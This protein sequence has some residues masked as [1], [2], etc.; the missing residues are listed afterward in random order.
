MTERT[1]Y[2]KIGEVAKLYNVGIKV[3]RKLIK[4]QIIPSVHFGYR[5]LRVPSNKLEMA[6]TK[7]TTETQSRKERKS[8]G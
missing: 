6:L 5:T 7:I 3:V 2:L 1:E 4:E 8:N